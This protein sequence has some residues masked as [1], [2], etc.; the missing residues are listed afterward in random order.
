[1][2]EVAAETVGWIV[3]KSSRIILTGAPIGP[4][5]GQRMSPL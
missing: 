4:L 5:L 3:A 1:M 2:K